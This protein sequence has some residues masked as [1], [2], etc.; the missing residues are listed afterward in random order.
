MT[1]D[2]LLK[3]APDH[4]SP[5]FL[6]YLRKHN[7]VLHEDCCWL[8]I[9][10]AKY[11]WPTA[12]AKNDHPHLDHLISKYGDHEWRVKPKSKR[13]VTRFHIHILPDSSPEV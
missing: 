11:G 5:E 13:T 6:D 2:E 4:N 12:F 1:Y 8:V 10:N 3:N 9:E 7:K